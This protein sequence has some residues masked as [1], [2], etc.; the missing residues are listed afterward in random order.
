MELID[1]REGPLSPADDRIGKG[2]S[3]AVRVAGWSGSDTIPTSMSRMSIALGSLR[4]LTVEVTKGTTRLG[5]ARSNDIILS[6]PDIADF[7]AVISRSSTG[8]V[9]RAVEGESLL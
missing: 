6:L 8:T 5:R 9:I 7:H 3:Q 1:L 4:L 2:N